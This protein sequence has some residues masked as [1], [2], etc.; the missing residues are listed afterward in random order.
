MDV[1]RQGRI[2]HI[3]WATH[4]DPLGPPVGVDC[5]LVAPM[6]GCQLASNLSRQMAHIRGCAIQYVT[7]CVG[8][9]MWVCM[10]VYG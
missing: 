4:I 8:V 1:G 10:G 6:A 7:A 9:Y 2:S 3:R 5:H